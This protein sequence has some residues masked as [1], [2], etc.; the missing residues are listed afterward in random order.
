MVLLKC[1]YCLMHLKLM[2]VT[3]FWQEMA[4]HRPIHP[5]FL[6]E[7]SGSIPREPIDV[8]SYEC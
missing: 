1:L 7:D 5:A 2:G 6:T 3:T 8:I 4:H